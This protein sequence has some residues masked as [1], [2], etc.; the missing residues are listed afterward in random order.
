[1][2]STIQ[3]KFKVIVED[4]KVCACFQYAT[5]PCFATALMV[6]ELLLPE[7]DEADVL[8]HRTNNQYSLGVNV[9]TGK[10]HRYEIAKMLH[11]KL[12]GIA[13]YDDEVALMKPSKTT[14]QNVGIDTKK[15]LTLVR[16]D[17]VD[18]VPVHRDLTIDDK[19]NM[20]SLALTGIQ[21]MKTDNFSMMIS[22]SL[23]YVAKMHED[24]GLV[25]LQDFTAEEK[26]IFQKTVAGEIL[27]VMDQ[28]E[29]KAMLVT[30]D[31]VKSTIQFNEDNV[32]VI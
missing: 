20:V 30:D 7:L 16:M 21:A 27:R 15:V 23:I 13:L 17:F 28:K 26:S 24:P 1:M 18:K 31:G 22:S 25:F 4:D 2:A 8:V 19:K 32:K 14:M 5:K 12:D 6:A 9:P 10:I 29:L 3:L 11:S